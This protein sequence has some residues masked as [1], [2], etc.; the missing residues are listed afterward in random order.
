VRNAIAQVSLYL[1]DE[2]PWKLVKV[3][4]TVPRALQVLAWS[5]ETLRLVGLAVLPIVPQKALELRSVL[6]VTGEVD[7][8]REAVFGAVPAGTPIGA[9]P[10]LFPRL[11]AVELPTE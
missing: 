10:N 2:A 3:E 8:T 4:A 7:F 6:G 11:D 9:P 5:A 1:S